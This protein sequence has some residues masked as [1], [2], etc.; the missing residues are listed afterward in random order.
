MRP[1]RNVSEA[2]AIIARGLA[3]RYRLPYAGGVRTDY[4]WIS[5]IGA[6]LLDSR[7]HAKIARAI[8]ALTTATGGRSQIGQRNERVS[9]PWPAK[10]LSGPPNDTRPT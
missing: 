9:Q 5:R 10:V 6:D 3:R 8:M 2:T 4:A 7:L 1:S